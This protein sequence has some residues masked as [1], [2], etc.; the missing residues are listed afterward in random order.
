[1]EKNVKSRLLKLALL[2]L[3]LLS[4]EVLAGPFSLY[5]FGGIRSIETSQFLTDDDGSGVDMGAR[6]YYAPGN[7]N[8]L[9]LGVSGTSTEYKIKQ[10]SSSATSSFSKEGTFSGSSYGPDIM[11]RMPW[12]S[13]SP[14]IRVSYLVSAHKHNVLSGTNTTLSTGSSVSTSMRTV[15][16]FTG[17][18]IETGVGVNFSYGSIRFFVEASETKETL[19]L[20]KITLRFINSDGSERL[21]ED[22]GETAIENDV[23]SL[24]GEKISHSTKSTL[25]GLGIQF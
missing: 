9:H 3:G 20:D 25:F 13:F 19:V 17:S 15:I 8:H 7:Q 21:A 1:L 24:I 16:D 2:L 14:Y 12:Q 11:V 5:G 4:K 18:G 23:Q 22:S 10:T 6:I